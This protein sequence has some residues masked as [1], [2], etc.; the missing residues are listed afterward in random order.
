MTDDSRIVKTV[1]LRAPVDRVWR[2]ISRAEEFG[3]WF[4]VRFEAAFAAGTHV[5]GV[6]VPTTVD[7]DV[8]AGQKPYEGRRFDITVERIEPMRHFSFRWHPFAVD[9]GVD[10]SGEPT[11]LVTFELEEVADGTRLTIT[12]SGFEAIPLERRAQAFEMNKQGWAMQA[13]LIEKYLAPVV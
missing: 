8:A 1:L 6:I 4:G 13:T 2:A 3:R 9:P 12:E 7:P 5:S 10:Y 11:T